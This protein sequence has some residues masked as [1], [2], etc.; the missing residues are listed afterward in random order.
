MAVKSATHHTDAARAAWGAEL[1]GWVSLLAAQCD[2]QG[3]SRVAAHTRRSTAAIS[4]VINHKYGGRYDALEQA[5]KG[6][7]AAATVSCPIVGE[8]AA[9]ACLDH[10]RAPFAA[11]NP[12]RVKLFRACRGGCTHSRLKS[13][14]AGKDVS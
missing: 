4:Q 5:V 13:G 6:A 12:T 10:Q 8:L 3:L 7:F 9:H 14:T 11:T 1:P 2:A